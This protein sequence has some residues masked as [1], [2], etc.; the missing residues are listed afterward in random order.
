RSAD[1]RSG[2]AQATSSSVRN[3]TTLCEPSQYGLMPDAPQRHSATVRRRRGAG[4]PSGRRISTSP[5]TSS[6]PCGPAGTLAQPVGRSV[7]MGPV[8]R[9]RRGPAGRGRSGPAACERMRGPRPDATLG[10]GPPIPTTPDPRS[11]MRLPTARG[12]LTEALAVALRR[13]P[14]P[15]P[16]VRAAAAAAVSATAGV[17]ADDDV[18]LAL[19]VMYELHYRGLDGV[20]ERWEWAPDLLAA[21][22]VV[23]EAFEAAVRER[24]PVPDTPA[25]TAAE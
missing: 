9:R 5:R 7:V 23:E 1:G 16:E 19:L 12:P 15:V 2:R 17:L 11:S 8:N 4:V 22:A 3:P 13:A 14:G 21:R 18:Q 6:G 25:R 20:D 10:T 24:V